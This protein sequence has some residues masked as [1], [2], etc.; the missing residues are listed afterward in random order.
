MKLILYLILRLLN[1][2]EELF[3]LYVIFSVCMVNLVICG[4][5]LVFLLFLMLSF[6]LFNVGF[7]C[8][9][10]LNLSGDVIEMYYCEKV[11]GELLYV[12]IGSGFVFLLF[13]LGILVFIIIVWL[14]L[15][16]LIERKNGLLEKIGEILIV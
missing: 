13:V 15:R 7:C 6:I 10:L 5:V 2:R 1:E 8:L 3:E 11:D 14:N 9:S 16:Y 4:L 12:L